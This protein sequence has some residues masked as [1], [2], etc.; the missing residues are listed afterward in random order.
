MIKIELEIHDDVISILDKVKDVADSGIELYIPKGSVL[1]DNMLNIKLL[2]K[3]V[4]QEGRTLHF[5]TDDELGQNMIELAENG[6]ASD[7]M[8]EEIGDFGFG[9][10]GGHKQRF[11]LFKPFSRVRS[12]GIWSRFKLG[13]VVV[14]LVILFVAAVGIVGYK[15]L[16]SP[17]AYVT[18][19]VVSQ[20]LARSL[21]I[22]VLKDAK[23]NVEFKV[24]AG[25]NIETSITGSMSA[26]TTGEKLVGE[27]AEGKIRI[28]NKTAFEIVLEEGDEVAYKDTSSD[29]VYKLKEDVTVPA[30]TEQDPTDPASPLLP[31]EAGAKV[32]SVEIGD[33]Y[34]IDAGE[35]LEFEEYKKNEL[36][37][38]ADGEFSGGSSELVHVVTEDDLV[39]LSAVL[40]DTN[41]QNVEAALISSVSSGDELVLGSQAV[42]IISEDFGNE[43]G[44][45]TETVDL[46]QVV[47]AV[48]LVYSEDALQSLIKDLIEEFIPEDFVISEQDR[49]IKVEVLGNSDGTI[50]SSTEADLQVTVKTFVVPLIDEDSLR[51]DLV[52]KSPSEAERVLGGIGNVESYSLRISPNIPFLRRVPSDTSR[53]DI[54]IDKE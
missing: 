45:E 19:T 5:Y 24:L 16:K 26:D 53:I 6:D 13:K 31:G 3:E 42:T 18:I 32:I 52:G 21:P 54:V 40:L 35:T 25:A 20:P 34:N 23:S 27:Q 44:D 22:K 10:N 46:T 1:F 30:H 49:E 39:S 7:Y 29:F 48:G 28:F 43:V 41:S 11:D 8:P 9:E 51:E 36:V 2:R 14:L 12:W 33:K 4:E 50:L 37:A 15:L 38:Q 17:K 47:A